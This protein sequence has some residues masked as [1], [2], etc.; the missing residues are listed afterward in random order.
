M[1]A[2]SRKRYIFLTPGNLLPCYNSKCEINEREQ[3][4]VILLTK[5]TR[6][7]TK[8]LPRGLSIIDEDEDIIVAEKPP[9]MLTMGTDKGSS[10]T[11]YYYLTDYV[12]KGNSRS[13]KRIFIVHRLDK[14]ASGILIFAKNENAKHRLQNQWKDATKKYLAVV[15]GQLEKRSDTIK[16]YL[17]ENRAFNVY[18]TQDK[19]KG[20]LSLTSYTVLKENPRCSLLDI[21]LLTG[22]KHQIRVHL[23]ES[24]HPIIGDKKYGKKV[25]GHTRLALHAF[26]IE[27]KHPTTGKVMAFETGMP[28]FIGKLLGD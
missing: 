3:Y 25:K 15:D 28:G 10:R 14:D 5:P 8:H 6:K 1:V 7:A 11:V 9:G 18:S 16:S 17:T 23:A 22:R 19:S 26:S 12:R 21:N 4:G 2:H 20:K 27:F 13:R 24:G